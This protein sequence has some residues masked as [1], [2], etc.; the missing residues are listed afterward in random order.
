MQILWM[1]KEMFI[2]VQFGFIIYEFNMY[3]M[4]NFN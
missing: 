4:Q 2:V 3:I 1:S